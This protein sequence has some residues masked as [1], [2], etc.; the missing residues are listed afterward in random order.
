MS[1]IE[2][3][4][5]TKKR[6]WYKATDLLRKFGR[7]ELNRLYAENKIEIRQGINNKVIKL[8]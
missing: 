8:K 3:F 2:A 4:L 7:N 6:V 1:E 5:A